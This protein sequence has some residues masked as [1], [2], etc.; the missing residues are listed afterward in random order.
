LP[1]VACFF[2]RVYCYVPE[3]APRSF[4]AYSSALSFA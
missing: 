1:F 4:P 3:A 2:K